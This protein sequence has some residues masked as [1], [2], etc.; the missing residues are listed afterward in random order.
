MGRK[1]RK[2]VKAMHEGVEGEGEEDELESK[3]KP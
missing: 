3:N 1:G 2:M